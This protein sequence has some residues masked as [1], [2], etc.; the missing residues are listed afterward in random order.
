MPLNL[1][2]ILVFLFAAGAAAVFLR[3]VWDLLGALESRSWPSA[4]GT[5][6]L[7]RLDE[8]RDGEETLYRAKI[9]YRFTVDGRELIGNRAYF[10]DSAQTTWSLFSRNLVARY[11]PGATV[12][13]YYDPAAPDEAVLEP[14]IS[15]ALVALLLFEILFLAVGLWVLRLTVTA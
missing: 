3:S 7:S 8:Q 4:P 14:G 11:L 6:T 13:V 10:G 12:T 1:A 5:V 2:T 15:G 9:S